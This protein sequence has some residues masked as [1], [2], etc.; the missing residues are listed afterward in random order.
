LTRFLNDLQEFLEPIENPRHLLYRE[1]KW[2]WLIKRKD[3]H[4][5]PEELGRKKEYAELFL[6]KWTESMGPAKLIYSRT[7]EG[8]KT[9]VQARMRAMSAVFVERAERL[10]VW[11]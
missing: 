11:K 3:Y 6:R 2:L 7:P 10:S 5:V 8:R 9:L 1:S 4:A